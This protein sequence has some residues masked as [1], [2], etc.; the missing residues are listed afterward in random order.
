MEIKSRHVPFS[1]RQTDYRRVCKLLHII[2]ESFYGKQ[3]RLDPALIF[4]VSLAAR[5]IDHSVPTD[6][7]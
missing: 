5:D 6:T 1:G 7:H 2:I 4:R 3:S